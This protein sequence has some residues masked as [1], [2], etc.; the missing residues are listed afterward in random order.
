MNDFAPKPQPGSV[1]RSL[2]LALIPLALAGG[3]LLWLQLRQPDPNP[4]RLGPEKG[5]P[6]ASQ[7]PGEAA[8]LWKLQLPGPL[9]GEFVGSEA[10]RACH[11]EIVEQYSKTGM[12]R[13]FA[14]VSDASPLEAKAAPEFTAAGRRYRVQTD[15]TAVAHTKHKHYYLV[16]TTIGPWGVD[17]TITARALFGDE[18]SVQA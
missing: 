9:T 6:V 13:S 12:G 10:C 15:G 4:A 11:A 3:G 14:M 8:N 7:H 16:C 18:L 17:V 2:L 1:I 5:E